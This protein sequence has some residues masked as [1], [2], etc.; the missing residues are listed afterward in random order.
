MG[1]YSFGRL[2]AP[3]STI[4]RCSQNGHVLLSPPT[5]WTLTQTTSWRPQDGHVLHGPPAQCGRLKKRDAAASLF[6]RLYAHMKL[7][8]VDF[9]GGDFNLAVKGPV[10]DVFSDAEFMAPGSSPLW[11]AGG[12]E[13]DDE[14]C[15]GFLCMP[16]RPFHWFVN[17]HGVHTFSNDQL[18]LNERDESTHYPVFMHLWATYLPG[19]TRA[20]LRSDAAQSRRLLKAATKND[21]KRQRRLNQAAASKVDAATSTA[22]A[23]QSQSTPSTY[24]VYP[25]DVFSVRCCPKRPRCPIASQILPTQCATSGSVIKSPRAAPRFSLRGCNV[26]A[27]RRVIV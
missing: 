25:Y 27:L 26:R 21:R 2:R 13:G 3:A 20:A 15:T 11:G 16:R 23:G 19:G 1:P 7:F 9:V 5:Q 24:P 4:G 10:A 6:Q 8:D 17:K 22:T 14:D 18:G 12:P